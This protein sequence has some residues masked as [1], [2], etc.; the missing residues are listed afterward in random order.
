MILDQISVSI[1]RSIDRER[2]RERFESTKLYPF[3]TL[4]IMIIVQN[5]HPAFKKYTCGSIE[6]DFIIFSV[7]LYGSIRFQCS[8]RRR[9]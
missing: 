1:D 2:E 5:T 9:N 6:L 3:L 8:L 4:D 7:V